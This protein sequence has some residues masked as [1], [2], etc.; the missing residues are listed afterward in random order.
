MLIRCAFR[1]AEL[2]EG[3]KGRIWFN[4]VLYMVFEGAMVSFCVL[5]LTVCHPGVGFCGRY[6]EANFQLRK[7]KKSVTVISP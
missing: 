5:V 7:N 2:S 6:R 3:F 1:I 4:E